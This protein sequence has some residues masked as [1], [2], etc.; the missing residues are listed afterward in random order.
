MPWSWEAFGANIKKKFSANTHYLLTR[1]YTPNKKIKNA[2]ER[3]GVRVINLNWMVQ[4]LQGK[5]AS[6]EAMTSLVLLTKN[7]FTDTNYKR[8]VTELVLQTV[9]AAETA[10]ISASV[11]ANSTRF[12][13]EH[14]DMD[15]E[16]ARIDTSNIMLYLPEG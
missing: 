16:M 5:V 14:A 9:E 6:V 1:K 10:V 7:N 15:A 12:E 3:E 13:D 2:E 8:A 4:L 11:T